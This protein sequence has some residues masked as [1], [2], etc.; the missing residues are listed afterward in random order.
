MI[1]RD[2]L[3]FQANR[4]IFQEDRGPFHLSGIK[5]FLSADTLVTA[6]TR[7]GEIS[8]RYEP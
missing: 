8:P 2:P 7:A 5:I 1:K 6:P 3:N 4:D